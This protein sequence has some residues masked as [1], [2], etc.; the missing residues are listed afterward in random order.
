[1]QK[2]KASSIILKI[3]KGLK[4]VEI[5]TA[6]TECY[7]GFGVKPSVIPKKDG[8]VFD[9]WD[10]SISNIT[11]DKTIKAKFKVA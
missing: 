11:A 4:R 7:D 8:Y 2:P 1:M 5:Y 3:E 10:T 9:G 6:K